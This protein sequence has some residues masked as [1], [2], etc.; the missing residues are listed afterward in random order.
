M[1]EINEQKVV[2]IL[3]QRY[4][5]D[6]IKKDVDKFERAAILKSI[7]QENKWDMSDLSRKFDIDT[8]TIRDWL[9]YNQIT[10]KQYEAQRKKGLSATQ[11]FHVLRKKN[12]IQNV[13]DTLSK[14]EGLDSWI[15]S[16]RNS[17]KKYKSFSRTIHTD[18]TLVLLADL[19]D[20]LNNLHVHIS[21]LEKK[22]NKGKV[23]T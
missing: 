18:K 3:K 14:V 7:M 9:L 19:I 12:G 16:T 15:V 21:L 23:T 10:P 20:D 2:E 1:D 11:I 13:Y 22:K 4:L 6:I 5:C 17:V 8:S